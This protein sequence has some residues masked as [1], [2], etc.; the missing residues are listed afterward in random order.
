M[1]KEYTVKINEKTNDIAI[2]HNNN[3]SQNHT[4][5]SEEL[6]Y[7]ATKVEYDHC[8]QRSEKLDNKVYIILTVYAFLFVLLCD[9]IK[10]ISD[11]SFPK[12]NSQLAWLIIYFIF[13]TLNVSLYIFTLI[14]LIHLLKGVSIKRFAPLIILKRQMIDANSKA[15]AKY[16]CS[17][18]NQ[19]IDINN[20]ILEKRFGKFNKCVNCFF[21][22]IIISI[23]LMFISNFIS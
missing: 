3:S 7:E 1:M 9:I 21:P 17:R 8:V 10:K 5:F 18:Y 4:D 15:V 19:C 13:L 22:I 23:F 2:K 12:N 14:Q 11:F 6:S 16:I 20:D